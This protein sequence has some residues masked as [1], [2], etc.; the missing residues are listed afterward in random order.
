M[1]LA[2]DTTALIT[3]DQK[4][5]EFFNN[6]FGLGGEW[7]WGNLL[8][9]VIA[10]LLSVILCGIVGFEREKRGRSAGLRTHLLVGVGSCMI[11]IVSIYGFPAV[12]SDGLK[13]SRD[14][15]R[16]AAQ[17]VA[18]VGFLGAGAIIHNNGGIK[19]LTTASTIWLVMAIGLCCGSMNF[20][21]AIGGTFVVMVVLI[22]FRRIERFASKSNPM[23]I[24]LAPSDVPVMSVLLSVAKDFGCAV[25]DVTSQIVNDGGQSCIEV[26][27]S[28]S[29][30][31]RREVDINSII[32][33]LEKKA[34]AISIQ[35]LNHH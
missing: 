28:M 1:I 16:L 17:V 34:N 22:S 13:V 18:G 10:I 25:T 11:M 8:L 7:P 24:M 35:V 6:N 12:F 30:E 19:G 15:A 5:A 32:P 27:F 23:F 26:T 14:A 21:L 2:T 33:I 29:A 4:I 20:I 9:C 3:I 31:H